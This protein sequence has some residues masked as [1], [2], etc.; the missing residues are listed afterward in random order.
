[1]QEV[2]HEIKINS[3]VWSST[4]NSRLIDLTC[5]A[6][7]GVP[8][9]S[10]QFSL[11]YPEDISVSPRDEISV[12]VGTENGTSLVF[13]G[14]VE[15]VSWSMDQVHIMASSKVRNLVAAYLNLYFERPFAGDIVSDLCKETEVETG[16]I[17]PGVS[18][19]FYAIGDHIHAYDHIR[20]LAL[21]NGFALYTDQDDKLIFKLPIPGNTH[22]FSYGINI[23]S[24]TLHEP[25]D[26]ITGVEIYGESPA[27]LGEGPM[28]A[29]WLTKKEVKG[30]AGDDGEVL[31]RIIDPAVRSIATG[32]LAAQA[33]LFT[34]K[35][36]R[37]GRLRVLGNPDIRIADLAI[38]SLMPI[39][40]QNGAFS[41]VGVKHQ[42]RSRK[43]FT[44]TL[45]IEE[46]I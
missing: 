12:S 39:G 23:L 29:N 5:H 38:I 15:Q 20:W 42:M 33:R 21:N 37:W 1:M 34:E 46:V 25:G 32:G 11:A 26:G 36:K 43:G 45:T 30:E 35:N 4:Q 2:S 44:T 24:L 17:D 28:A 3:D 16:Q 8:V 9:N 40:S 14:L 41:I 10:C 27:S 22:S 19:D 13:T 7:Q 18:L 6:S 31:K